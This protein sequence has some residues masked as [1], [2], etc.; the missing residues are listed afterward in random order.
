MQ[1]VIAATVVAAAALATT[2]AFA[3]GAKT[4]SE[5]KPTAIERLWSDITG[6]GVSGKNVAFDRSKLSGAE[7]VRLSGYAPPG[8]PHL[9]DWV[10]R[11]R[12]NRTD[13][14]NN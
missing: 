10:R 5:A 8:K 3:E 6:S 14:P 11:L 12:T 13:G 4:A 9:D 2:G 7:I 1:K